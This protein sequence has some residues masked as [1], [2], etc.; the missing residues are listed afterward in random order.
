ME[1][2]DSHCHLHKFAQSGQLNDVLTRAEQAGVT[3]MI[4]VG[5]SIED[6][7]CYRNLARAH[8]GQIYWTVGI[9]PCYVTEDWRDQSA[10]L[11]VWFVDDWLPVAVGE[12]GLDY[13]HLPKSATEAEAIKHR[14]QEAFAQQLSIAYQFDCPVI[15]HSRDAFDDCVAMI[16]DSGVNWQKVVFHCFS[17]GVAEINLLNERGGRGS[18]TGIVTYKNAEAVRQAMLTQGLE[19]LMLETDA[20]YLAPVPHRGE[21]CEPAY[22]SHTAAACADLFGVSMEALTEQTAGNTQNFFGMNRRE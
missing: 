13:F 18:F 1:I 7:S 2:I 11:S 8:P 14:Q 20:P 17:A 9:H 16:D 22:L 19:R 6:W 12:I 21:L 10:A 3:R 5:T 4:A 15:I